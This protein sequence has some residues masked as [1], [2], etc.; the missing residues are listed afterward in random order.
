MVPAFATANQLLAG[1]K[2]RFGTV[3]APTGMI[4]NAFI[5]KGEGR[6]FEMTRI[7]EPL[8]GFRDKTVVITGLSNPEANARPGEGTGDH[9]RAGSGFLTCS[10]A[11][12]TEGADMFLGTSLDQ[13]MAKEFGRQTQLPS[14]ELT[15]SF[16]NM[17]GGCDPGY[18][19]PYT[20]TI[21]WSSPT[22]PVPMETDPR[23]VFERLFGDV[24]T[25]NPTERLARMR[26]QRSLLDSLREEVAGL[27]RHLGA[28]DGT[29]LSEYLD[30]VRDIERRIQLAEQQNDRE[31]VAFDQPTGGIPRRFDEHASILLDLQAVALQ[32]DLTR[33]FTFMINHDGSDRAYPEIGIADAHH[34]LT[35][36]VIDPEAV[37]K[38]TKINVFMM[39]L[40]AN[41]VEKLKSIPDGD[42]TLLDNTVL[43]YGSGISNGNTHSHD[44]LP[45]VVVG[46]GGG[47]I[48]GGRHLRKPGERLANLHASLLNVM[49]IPVSH[50]GDS[51]GLLEGLA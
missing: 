37:E 45:I 27:R 38:V 16:N 5:P 9:S 51:S 11:K 26:Q 20:R 22:N 13:I 15:C 40:F 6:A 32:S 43:L 23:V 14:M 24:S 1:R 8:A 49:G 29:K 7:L 33:V 18:A 48:K 2:L 19:C 28:G 50:F 39:Q 3:Y 36:N 12:K 47:Q 42:G 10:H 44:N 21:V 30:S 46:G 35:H 17:V 34:P 25:T 4:M 41:F 31:L